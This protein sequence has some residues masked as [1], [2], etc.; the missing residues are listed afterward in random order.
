MSEP[1]VDFVKPQALTINF[2]SVGAPMTISAEG[3]EIVIL[4]RLT[5]RPRDN[6]MNVN[7]DVSTGGNR[8]PVTCFDK[9]TPTDVSRYWRAPL[10]PG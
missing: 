1:K 7:Y 6:V 9:N 2:P 10:P 4:V 3:D 8:A 5:F